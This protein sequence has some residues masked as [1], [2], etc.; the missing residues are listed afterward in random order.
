M[1]NEPSPSGED[2]LQRPSE[3]REKD[4]LTTAAAPLSIGDRLIYDGRDGRIFENADVLPR[5]FAA[6][7]RTR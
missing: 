2:C 3:T 4:D 1:L 7:V 6:R 5:F